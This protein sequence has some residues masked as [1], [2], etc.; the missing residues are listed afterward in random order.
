MYSTALSNTAINGYAPMGTGDKKGTGSPACSCTSPSLDK[1]ENTPGLGYINSPYQFP[2]V[3]DQGVAFNQKIA[4]TKGGLTDM[5][6]SVTIGPDATLTFPT[7]QDICVETGD[8]VRVLGY[9]PCR[10][11]ESE[12]FEV[13]TVVNTDTTK[14][15]Q[16]NG[17]TPPAAK[18]Y[19]AVTTSTSEVLLGCISVSQVSS[20]SAGP[21]IIESI[22]ADPK[23]LVS[24]GASAR[25]DWSESFG[26][27]YAS[28]N[29]WIMSRV[30]DK[31][32]PGDT[33]VSSDAGLPNP[34]RVMEV[35]KVGTSDGDTVERIRLA[36]PPQNTGCFLSHVRRGRLFNFRSVYGTNGMVE[37][38]LPASATA[39][40]Q[41][42]DAWKVD[43]EASCDVF[44][45]GCYSVAMH[46]SELVG[47]QLVNHSRVILRGD[48]FIRASHIFD[49]SY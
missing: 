2:L 46:W 7:S 8:S 47:T 23:I 4:L 20:D 3:I 32:R 43:D 29:S 11:D 12:V 35:R 33:I 10:P 42:L 44:S 37:L 15:V 21:R 25:S 36:S 24:G 27:E 26:I 22:E 14:S 28:G 18:T 39:G 40:L 30:L 41:L 9:D 16:L 17:F 48:V 6:N 45:V 34:V 19:R 13:G 5:A 1:V 49:N 38:K 31:V